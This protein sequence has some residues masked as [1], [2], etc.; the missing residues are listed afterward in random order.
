MTF[1]NELFSV[2][3]L[4]SISEKF[5]DRKV[6]TNITYL[7]VTV[8]GRGPPIFVGRVEGEGGG[9]SPTAFKIPIDSA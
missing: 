2:L 7:D 3:K 1:T 6:D 8:L 4:G 5:G 9:N